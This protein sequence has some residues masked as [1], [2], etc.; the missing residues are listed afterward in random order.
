MGFSPGEFPTV[1]LKLLN[2]KAAATGSQM[3][4]IQSK[5]PPRKCGRATMPE[6]ARG[7]EAA[8]WEA[9]EG[10]APQLP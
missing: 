1:E 6:S 5:A 9:Q 7:V 8:S 3:R 2:A 10:P 4:T